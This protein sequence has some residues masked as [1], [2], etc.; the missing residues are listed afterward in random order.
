MIAKYIP[1]IFWHFLGYLFCVFPTLLIVQ[2]IIAVPHLAE[3]S[4]QYL[5]F[6]L[7]SRRLKR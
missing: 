7:P 5:F 1:K 4:G 2:R 3:L 6:F